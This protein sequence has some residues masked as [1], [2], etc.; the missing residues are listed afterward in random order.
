MTR[1]ILVTGGDGQLGTS[2]MGLPRVEGFE[3]IA[4]GLDV[5]DFTR[6]ETLDAVLASRPWAAVINGA[7]HTAVDRAESEPALAWTINAAA[8]ARIAQFCASAGVPMVQVSTDYVYP[9]DKTGPY[10]EEDLV[11]PLGVYG[12][13]KAAGEWAV[14][15]AVPR[16][17]IARTSWVVS[18]FGANFVKTMLRLGAERDALRVVDDQW[19]APT[20]AQDLAAVLLQVTLRLIADPAAPTGV[21]HMV[22]RGE[23]TWRRVAEAV[24]ER[25][26]RHGRKVPAVTPISTADYPTPARRPLNSRLSTARLEQAYGIV[27]P[28]WRDAV[29]RIVDQLLQAETSHR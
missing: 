12:A 2:L 14:R 16:H 19:G 6:P 20:S 27:L 3:L 17:V 18:P 11:G 7:A 9:G 15:A 1:A 29:D 24:F 23:T 21:F 4:P 22:N 26:A 13:S 28:E 8:P 10:L 5:L 25:A